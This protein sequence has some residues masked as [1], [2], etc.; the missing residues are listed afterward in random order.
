MNDLEHELAL[1]LRR[2]PAPDGFADRVLLAARA[3]RNRRWSWLAAAS[4][5]VM[6]LPAGYAYHVHIQRQRAEAQLR[7]ALT[8]AS[9]KLNL[10]FKHLN[11]DSE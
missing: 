4:L 5:V 10:A 11:P 1:A 3:R 2:Q 6:V 9:E 7:L 8:V